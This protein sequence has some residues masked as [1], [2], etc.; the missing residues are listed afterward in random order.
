MG[1]KS[2]KKN[3]FYSF[4]KSFMNI[5]FPII[6][7]PYVSRILTPESIGRVNFS[8]SVVQ[9][10]VII[11]ALGINSY[12][13]REAAKIKN[14]REALSKFV[15]ELFTINIIST[16]IS[17]L[18]F[19]FLL[20]FSDFLQKYRILL[21]ICSSKIIFNL[22]SFD[23][24]YTAEEEF[25]YITLRSIFFQIIALVYLFIFVRTDA[26]CIKYAIFGIIST[27]GSNI[28]NFFHARKFVTFKIRKL[29]LKIH[30]K[31]IFIFFGTTLVISIYSVLD[32]SM[33][34]FMSTDV[35][36]GFYSVATKITNM[37]TSLL[38]SVIGILLPRLS[39]YIKEELVE[40]YSKLLVKIINV[41]I[42]LTVPIVCGLILLSRQIIEVF[43]GAQYVSAV[44]AMNIMSPV[45]LLCV[46]ASISGNIL[47]S[48]NKERV[49]L[50][51]CIF[52]AVSNIILNSIFIPMYGHVGAAF[53]TLIAQFI[54]MIFQVI[55][56]WQY[57]FNKK[58]F[59]NLISVLISSFLMSVVVYFLMKNIQNLILNLLIS[60]FSGILVYALFLFITRN[61]IF[62]ENVNLLKDKFK[63]AK[64]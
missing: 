32:T 38:T 47:L 19:V 9:Y 15:Q 61:E 31:S 33:L 16:F 11:A 50:I 54:V 53:A 52:G 42:V 56:E 36:V 20:I 39:F 30:L 64:K 18:L 23:W 49:S 1:E 40:E 14:D 26:D 5:A 60:V 62:I 29:N 22:I 12:G 4:L 51:A 43:S 24:L 34:G 10:F 41:M 8:N 6:T 37:V 3:A 21:L 59:I 35:E 17:C 7:F 2:L 27:V 57:F 55:P 48:Q 25:K 28:V 13:V 46:F 63:R 44:T 45:V 58:I